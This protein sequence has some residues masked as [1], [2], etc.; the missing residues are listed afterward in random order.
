MLFAIDRFHQFS[1]EK[2]SPFPPGVLQAWTSDFLALLKSPDPT[3][4]LIAALPMG[5]RP[6]VPGR[7]VRKGSVISQLMSGL[8]H[9]DFSLRMESQT[10]LEKLTIRESC[11]DPTDPDYQREPEIK[12]WEKWW[13]IEKKRIAQQKL[14]G[15]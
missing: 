13:S 9:S 14:P 8:R 12:A 3:V 1:R 2:A 15:S 11:L 5:T 4:R 7:T 10:V 6:G